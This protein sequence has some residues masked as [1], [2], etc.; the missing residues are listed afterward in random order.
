MIRFKDGV[1]VQGIKTQIW[2]A[3]QV[4]EQ[5]WAGFPL[6]VTSLNDGQHVAGSL[7]YSGMA[8]DLRTKN[9]PLAIKQARVDDLAAALPEGY[10]VLLEKLGEENEHCHVHY[11]GL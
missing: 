4:A 9:L 6:T 7:H 11:G 2:L 10:V 3:I 8:V 1:K 5:I